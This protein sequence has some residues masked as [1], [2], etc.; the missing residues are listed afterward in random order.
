MSNP[1]IRGAVSAF[2]GDVQR[3]IAIAASHPEAQLVTAVDTLVTSLAEHLGIAAELVHEA[4]DQE[5]GIRPD[6]GALVTGLLSGYIELKAPGKG[7][8]P[9]RFTDSH[10]RRQWN[11]FKELPNV[12]YTDGF[13]WAL[14]RGGVRVAVCGLGELRGP[15]SVSSETANDLV[16]LLQ[17]FFTWEPSP[18]S[19]P[20]ALAQLLAPICRLLRDDVLLAAVNPDSALNSMASDWRQVLF[21]EADDRQFADAYAQ[22]LT[23][24]LLLARLDPSTQVDGTLTAV[25]ASEAIEEGYGLLAQTLRVLSDP[26][27]RSEIGTALELLERVV[28]SIVPEQLT[29]SPDTDIWLYFYEQF[30]AEYDPVLREERGVYYTPVEVVQAQVRLVGNVLDR[31][32]GKRLTFA[33]DGVTVLDPAIGTGTYALAAFDHGIS[34]VTQRLGGGAVAGR[35]AVLAQNLHGFEILVGPYTVA[36]LRLTQRLRDSGVEQTRDGVKVYLTDTLES[37]S[38][39]DH[40]RTPAVLRRLSRE[41][42]RAQE[43][44][45]DARILVCIGNPPYRRQS[46]S[47]RTAT[48]DDADVD[49]RR[50]RLLGDFYNLAVGNTMFSHIASLYNDYVYFW[51]W[52]MWKVLDEGTPGIVSFITASSFLTGPGFRGMREVM[53]RHFD[54]IWIIDLE[55]DNRGTNVTENVFAIETPV[56]IAIGVRRGQAQPDSPAVVNYTKVTGSRSEKLTQL[57]QITDFNDLDWRVAPDVWHELFVVAPD[58]AYSTWS[59][60]TQLFPWQH[61]GVKLGRTWPYAPSEQSLIRRWER[62]A[63]SAIEERSELFADRPHGRNSRTRPQAGNWPPPATL[64]PIVDVDNS[65]PMP[66]IARFSHRSLDRKWIL[67]DARL[68]RTPSPPIWSTHSD[69]QIY[70]TS[71]LTNALGAGPAAIAAAH[72][73]DLHHFRGSFGGKDV[74]PLWRD[75]NATQAN[76]TSGLLEQLTTR[77]GFEVTGPELFAYVYG[78]LS[79]TEFVDRYREEVR[80]PPVRVPVTTSGDAFREAARLGS[81]LLWLHTYGERSVPTDSSS[82]DIP[83]GLARSVTPIP[84]DPAG[85]PRDF[86]YDEVNQVLRV[87]EGT[88]GPV[89]PDVY[90]FEVSGYQVVPEWLGERKLEPGGRRSSPLDDIR[91][92]CWPAQFT[93]ELLELLWVVEATVALQPQLVDIL[94]RVLDC[95]VFTEEELPSPTA[96]DQTAPTPQAPRDALQGALFG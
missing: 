25:R 92:D 65:S 96:E 11:R 14:Y 1:Q 2:L 94:D 79:S 60:I 46:L 77:Y 95:P 15:N 22:T 43:V 58:G 19:S 80:H 93:T 28:G 75:S 73:P 45:D 90:N 86:E 76:V 5:L 20:E 31:D 6:I 17:D 49:A 30:L 24:A 67:A 41:H 13:Q 34:R 85:Y 51:R 89:S 62:L 50:E 36:H 61:A 83:P 63:S 52:A 10:D 23:Y 26:E 64:E 21:P 33:D 87:G 72:P 54:E 44:K 42:E 9:E 55:G 78:L 27:L 4:A 59:R 29:R 12:I 84:T 3:R 74:I 8:D 88:F 40:A 57:A 56:A 82:G 71:L 18:P 68:M 91:P 53:R 66:R 35:A 38:I 39:D 70:M 7:A 32:F 48:L 69:Q 37:P 47:D 81:R 16:R